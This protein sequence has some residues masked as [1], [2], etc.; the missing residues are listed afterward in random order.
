VF[1]DIFRR[2]RISVKKEALVNFLTDPQERRST[3][4]PSD[5]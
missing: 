3:I 5:E 2:V 1:F 4:R